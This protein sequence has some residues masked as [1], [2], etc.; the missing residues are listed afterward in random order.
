MDI[1]AR[2]QWHWYPQYQGYLWKRI[3]LSDF[4]RLYIQTSSN[5]AVIKCMEKRD[6]LPY[7]T[8]VAFPMEA[9]KWGWL[10][11]SGNRLG[12]RPRPLQHCR[13][14]VLTSKSKIIVFIIKHVIAAISKLQIDGIFPLDAI[15]QKTLKYFACS[16]IHEKP[17][18]SVA[19]PPDKCL[20]P[21]V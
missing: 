3:L 6:G 19:N 12:T 4:L 8:C 17:R 14:L 20:A 15:A 9:K 10:Q 1:H 7:V 16:E 21:E 18:S 11:Y 2:G 13:V 5:N